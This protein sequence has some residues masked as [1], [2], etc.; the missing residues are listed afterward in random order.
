MGNRVLIV[1]DGED[2]I[3][4]RALDKFPVLDTKGNVY[5]TDQEFIVE[6]LI[7]LSGDLYAVVITRQAKPKISTGVYKRLSQMKRELL[8][9]P[10]DIFIFE[11]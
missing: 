4:T 9:L 3:K 6:N 10:K 1:H 2:D 11:D 7:G 8:L 5:T